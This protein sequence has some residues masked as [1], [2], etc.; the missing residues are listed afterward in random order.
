MAG[1]FIG[2]GCSSSLGKGIA[3]NCKVTCLD[4]AQAED[5]RACAQA[6]GFGIGKEDGKDIPFTGSARTWLRENGYAGHGSRTKRVPAFVYEGDAELIAQFIGA[7][8][9]CDGSINSKGV[10]RNGLPRKDPN[11]AFYSVNVPLLRDVQ[12]LLL[13]LGIQSAIRDKKANNNNYTKGPHVSY[14]LEIRGAEMAARFVERVPVFGVKKERLKAWP[15]V[16]QRFDEPLLSDEVVSVEAAGK[17][18]CRCFTV[19]EDHTFTSDDLVVHNSELTSRRLPAYLLGRFPDDEII[20]CSY[21]A[22]LAYKM[23]RDV[24]RIMDSPAYRRLFPGTALYDKNVRTLAGG[25]WLRNSDEFEVVGRRGGYRCAGLGG[26]ISGR[27]FRWGIID[28]PIKGADMARS[29]TIREGQWEWLNSDFFTRQMPDARMLITLTR[30]HHDDIVGRLLRQDDDGEE[31]DMLDAG[32]AVETAR[33]DWD[34]LRLPAIAEDVPA[35]PGDPRQPGEA[36]WPERYPLAFLRARERRMGPYGF[37]SLYQQNPTPR[38]G[39]LFTLAGLSHYVEACRAS[40]RGR[41]RYYD[42]GYSAEGDWTVGVRMA[43]L[44]DGTYV[45]EDVVRVRQHPTERNATIKAVAQ[46]DDDEFGQRVQIYVEQPPGAGVETTNNLIKFLAG[47]KVKAV[48]PRGKKEERAEAVAA[49]VGANN[50]LLVRAK[51]NRAFVDE[52]IQFN[53]GQHDDQ[54]DAFSG[55]FNMLTNPN[56]LNVFA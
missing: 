11:V 56:V 45:V 1:Y 37:G 5:V 21:A 39:G 27:G 49:Q 25:T 22:S 51:W 48:Q 29:E 46:R 15:F 7:Y 42:K 14:R 2:D 8:F 53:G 16:R 36:L 19:E 6:L 4:P 47:H 30:W 9:A 20:A 10:A 38:E 31:E 23:N 13:R 50:V 28:D 34:V 55:A 35:H 17:L 12:H 26:G 18:P 32:L 54:V 3:I 52:L 44:H 33:E 41:C 43:R 40:V 24:Q